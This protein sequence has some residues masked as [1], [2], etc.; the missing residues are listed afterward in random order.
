[1]D[2]LPKPLTPVDCDLRDFAYVP[3]FR[4]R[5]LGSSFHAR[6]TDA[7]WRAGVTLWLRSWD[8]V[9][10]GSLPD[11][12][13]DLCRLAELGRDLKLWRKIRPGAMRGWTKCSDGRLYHPVV[14]EGVLEAWGRRQLARR[15]GQAG[16]S[17]RWA[18]GIAQAPNMDGPA[19]AP[20]S[21]GIT[22]D[23]PA[24]TPNGSSN[25]TA[26]ARAMPGDSKGRRREGEGKEVPSLRSGEPRGTRL[27][28]DWQPS[29][30][31]LAFAVG[32][33]VNVEVEVR[34]FRNYWVAKAGKD[35]R[36]LDW[37]RT[38]ENWCDSAAKPNSV[39]ALG[40]P[41]AKQVSGTW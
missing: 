22:D 5:L 32:L 11:D 15:K 1:M 40:H 7:E 39:L 36:K 19:I 12:D 34:K 3:M 10:A 25:I 18:T 23:A 8:Q 20:D 28:E 37:E 38:W 17:K 41:A 16:A 24:I 14:A 26:M 6:A 2:E 29:P 13:I 35:A 4:S 33:G 31:G 9:P 27:Q 30:R 21:T